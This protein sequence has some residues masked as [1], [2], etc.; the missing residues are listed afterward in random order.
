MRNILSIA[1]A[2]VAIAVLA[3]LVWNAPKRPG[4]D[5]NEPTTAQTE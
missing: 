1:A 4:V 5:L 3:M 2:V